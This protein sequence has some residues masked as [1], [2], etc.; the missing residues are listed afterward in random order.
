MRAYFNISEEKRYR[1]HE[2]GGECGVIACF[3]RMRRSRSD[4]MHLYAQARGLGGHAALVTV[5]N[6]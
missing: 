5:C 1:P 2:F 6:G 4:M 3:L